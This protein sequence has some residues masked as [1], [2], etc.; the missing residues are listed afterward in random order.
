MANVTEYPYA[1]CP[2][3]TDQWRTCAECVQRKPSLDYCPRWGDH[4]P[5]K[6]T[7][8]KHGVIVRGSLL[9]GSLPW[10][11][12]RICPACGFKERV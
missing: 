8:A 2:H 3:G 11:H 10:R 6:I 4:H 5:S 1:P 7:G 12:Y 9:C